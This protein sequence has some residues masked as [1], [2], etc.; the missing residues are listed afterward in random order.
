MVE[1]AEVALAHGLHVVA[2]LRVAHAGPGLG[3]CAGGEVVDREGDVDAVFDAR[4][5]LGFEEP[6]DFLVAAGGAI[7][8]G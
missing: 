2:C 4:E 7:C 5:G 6:E 8:G 1:E 3:D